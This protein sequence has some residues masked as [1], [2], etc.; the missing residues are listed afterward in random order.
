MA[1]NNNTA[2]RR[3]IREGRMLIVAEMYKKGYSIKKIAEEVKRRMNTTCSTRTIWNDIN[4]LL[5]EWRETRIEDIDLRLQFE[6]ECIDDNICE[7]W[8]QWEKSKE[9]YTKQYSKRVGIPMPQDASGDGEGQGGGGGANEIVTIRREQSEQNEVG[10]GDPRYIAEIRQQ[11]M[12]RRKLLGIYAPEKR[13]I[14]CE[15]TFTS[16][17]MES[18]TIDEN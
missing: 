13:D 5:K 4:A 7:L 17:L 12:E 9:D 6:L 1:G 10:L 3:H 8:K 14:S 11:Q 16:L 15:T 18:G 2:S